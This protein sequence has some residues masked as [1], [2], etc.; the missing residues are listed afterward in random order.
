M[1]FDETVFFLN[2]VFTCL[3]WNVLSYVRIVVNIYTLSRIVRS[4]I[5]TRSSLGEKEIDIIEYWKRSKMAGMV[6]MV[7]AQ[8]AV[9]W[10]RRIHSSHVVLFHKVGIADYHLATTSK[11]PTHLRDAKRSS[12]ILVDFYIGLLFGGIWKR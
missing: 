3:E 12:R 11:P 6:S 5:W 9:R 8:V 2:C 1:T 7:I 4:A 10:N